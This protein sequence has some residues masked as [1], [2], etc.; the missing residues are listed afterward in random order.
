MKITVSGLFYYPVKSCAGIE[1]NEALIGK[2][3]IVNDRIC[4]LVDEQNVF[5]SQR[6]HPLLALI[7]P[8]ING[9]NLTLNLP[10]NKKFEV[11]L[12]PTTKNLLKVIVW[13]DLCEAVDLGDEAAKKMSSYLGICCRLVQMTDNF[14]RSLD[15][16]FAVSSS[17]QTGFADG[18][19]FL[20]I[21][22]ASLDDL[23]RRMEKPLPMNRFRPN[24]VVKGC[25]PYAE[26]TWKKI[27]IGSIDFD[28]VKPCSRCSVTTVDQLTAEKS[29]EPL[30]TLATYRTDPV[31]GVLFGQNM[32][33]RRTGIIRLDQHIEIVSFQ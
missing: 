8:Q 20:L 23:N 9:Q 6:R 18:Y 14:V 33:H 26:D 10:G 28:L 25:E 27:R 1:L 31:E 30:S 17:D 22:E 3:G 7:R 24:I 21:S 29:K 19:P 4:M 32:I 12:N 11:S 16:F 5:L 13:D 15:P 2:R